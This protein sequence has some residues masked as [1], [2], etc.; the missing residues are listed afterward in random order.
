M[1][2]AAAE[3]D[4]RI[5]GRLLLAAGAFVAES[6]EEPGSSADGRGSARAHRPGA[7]LAG[8]IG[9]N[10]CGVDDLAFGIERGGRAAERH[11]RPVSLG[12]GGEIKDKLRRLADGDHQHAAGC[13][14]ERSRVADGSRT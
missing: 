2:G 8:K 11:R 14:I 1:R 9:W 7:E 10:G 12:L 5:D 4:R 3:L 6:A 13:G